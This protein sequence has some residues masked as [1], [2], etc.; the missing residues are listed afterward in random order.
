MPKA[1]SILLQATAAAA[2]LMLTAAPAQAARVMITIQNL[3]PNHSISFAPLRY[4]FNSGV[5]DAFNI[6]ST[7]TAPIISIAEGGSGS[8]WLPAFAAAD[9]TAVIGSLGGA[10]TPGATVHSGLITVDPSVNAFFTFGS[11]VI[12]SNDFFIGNDDPQEYRLFDA[13]GR[14]A[15]RSINVKA[16]EIWNAGSEAFDPANAAFLV[17]GTNSLRTPE[18]SVV[19]FNF[20][21]LAG[22]D[23]LTT[24]AGYVFSSGLTADQDVYRISFSAT[25]EPGTWA[26]MIVGFGGAGWQI[27]RRRAA[28]TPQSVAI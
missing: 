25:P 11:M 13:H 27:R 1:R 3:A 14:L 26:M 15:I 4:G 16:S 23:G 24:A 21:E 28:E 9:P 6:G 22:F 17:G 19:S 12:P 7:A 20:A 2:L 5:F 18:N 8:A 10:L